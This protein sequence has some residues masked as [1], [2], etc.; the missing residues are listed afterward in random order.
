MYRMR[1][2]QKI[3]IPDYLSGAQLVGT[4]QLG[5]LLNYTPVHI[6]RLVNQGKLPSPMVIGGRKLAWRVSDI[7]AFLDGQVADNLAK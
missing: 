1:A 3:E 5:N 4:A 7:K 2:A 6:R